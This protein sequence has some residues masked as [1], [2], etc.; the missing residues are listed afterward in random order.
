MKQSK[1]QE[2]QKYNPE[3]EIGKKYTKL[4]VAVS[5]CPDAVFVSNKVINRGHYVQ[6]VL[7]GQ[8]LSAGHIILIEDNQ[9]I[10]RCQLQK[11]FIFPSNLLVYVHI[12]ILSY[13]FEV[14]T[15][16]LQA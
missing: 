2:N 11:A 6:F 5:H 8:N 12:F 14:M 7:L 1:N 16:A 4:T 10:I 9:E 13:D 3:P 15:L